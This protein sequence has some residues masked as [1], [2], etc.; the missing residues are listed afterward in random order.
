MTFRSTLVLSF[1]LSALGACG[2]D[3][4]PSSQGYTDC[5]SVTCQPG[6]Y[7]EDSRFSSC[8]DGCLS[9]ANC[10]GN[11]YCDTADLVPT[12]LNR[13][14]PTPM[15]GGPPPADRLAACQSAC[16]HFQTCGLAAGETAQCRSDCAALTSDQ[17]QAV[18]TSAVRVEMQAPPQPPA[19]DNSLVNAEVGGRRDWFA[20]KAAERRKQTEADAKGLAGGVA[21]RMA[22]FGGAAK[23]PPAPAQPAPAPA[24]GGGGPADDDDDYF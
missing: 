4:A 8:V 3:A 17:Q 5:G 12:C 21:A 19:R 20:E 6:Q 7:C 10:L 24:P 18:A 1:L 23:K 22:M 16:D 2:D 9:D 11:Q 13:S 14:T 15:D